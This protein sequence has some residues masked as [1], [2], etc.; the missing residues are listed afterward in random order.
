MRRR[1][2]FVQLKHEY[3]IYRDG[4]LFEFG[5]GREPRVRN[6]VAGLSNSHPDR[7]WTYDCWKRLRRRRPPLVVIN[8]GAESLPAA[9]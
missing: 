7:F 8:N 5:D 1:Y 6:R 2:E 3:A 9:E 4:I